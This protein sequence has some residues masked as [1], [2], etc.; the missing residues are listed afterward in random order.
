MQPTSI[1][2]DELLRLET[3]KQEALE[4]ASTLGELYYQK[5]ILELQIEDQRAKVIQIR[6]KETELFNELQNKYGD[7]SINISTGDFI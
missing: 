3:I 2:K 1:T 7:V 6:A 5:T 4:V